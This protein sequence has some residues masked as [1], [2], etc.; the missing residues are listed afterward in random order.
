MAAREWR[1]F[2]GIDVDPA[3]RLTVHRVVRDDAAKA[4]TAETDANATAEDRVVENAY[5]R[6]ALDDNVDAEIGIGESD[7]DHGEATDG[8][9]GRVSDQENVSARGRFDQ[10]GSGSVR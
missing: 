6:E 1:G 5:P 7:R 9:P 10:R 2:A 3:L 4:R 8:Y